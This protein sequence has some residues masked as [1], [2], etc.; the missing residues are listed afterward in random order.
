MNDPAGDRPAVVSRY[1]LR[2][3]PRVESLLGTDEGVYIVALDAFFE[4]LAADYEPETANGDT[5]F[6]SRLSLI[7]SRVRPIVAAGN[8][9]KL[10]RALSAIRHSRHLSNKVRHEFRVYA[11]EDAVAATQRFLAF[12]EVV[13]VAHPVL[14]RLREEIDRHWMQKKS[15]A[16]YHRELREQRL[17]LNRFRKEA[18]ELAEQVRHLQALEEDLEAVRTEAKQY[19]LELE[20]TRAASEKRDVRLDD[21]RRRLNEARLREEELIRRQHDLAAAREYI[22][23]ISRF[24]AYTRS[25]ADYERSVMLL[26]DE[27]HATVEAI[28]D[29][30]D[31]AIKGPAGTG[32]TL[33]LMHAVHQEMRERAEELP[34]GEVEEVAVFTFNKS[35]TRF[36][37]YL[38]RIIG[39][40]MP[41]AVIRHVDAFYQDQIVLQNLRISYE[42]Q[43]LKEVFGQQAVPFLTPE[44]F[45]R[46]VEEF[47][48]GNDLERE[49]YL[50]QTT[51]RP[52]RGQA[53]TRT[54]R[55]EVWRG[56]RRVIEEMVRRGEVSR[57]YAVCLITQRLRDDPDYRKSLLVRRVFLDE[58]Q[59]LSAAEI[60]LFKVIS[61]KGIVLAGD[62]QQMIYR[63]GSSYLRAGVDIRGRTR[64][65]RTNYRNTR[66]ICA[67]A[68]AYRS[69]RG[70]AHVEAHDE[71]HDEA[72]AHD[73]D[74]AQPRARLQDSAF[75]VGPGPE[76][77]RCGS[78]EEMHR[79]L[80]ERI[81]FFLE[82]LGYEAENLAVLA[83]RS[84]ILTEVARML[85]KEEIG[86]VDVRT[87]EFDFETSPGIRLSTL[88]SAKGLEFPVVF[89]VLPRLR[90]NRDIDPLE[91]IAQSRNLVHVSLTRAMDN[92]QVFTL[93]QPKEEALKD[94]ASAFERAQA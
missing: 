17:S 5:N 88:H 79:I 27:Q 33:V 1:S 14:Q 54:Q 22:D 63:M 52:G 45:H 11:L 62:E 50:E 15:P 89:L 87:D 44:E 53:L 91:A 57:Q 21:L 24:T 83:S 68:E 7:E 31:F 8:H 56:S 82:T 75:R 43:Y 72:R 41:D 59:D 71:A 84:A 76:H 51:R 38:A 36:N 9:R 47:I 70:E 64:I 90:V 85:E 80:A 35:L 74:Q 25:R 37:R 73:G 93:R 92:L 29:S 26:S 10:E 20:K 18:T 66:E 69:I 30:A 67:L 16:E 77:F 58:T 23:Y 60:A 13:A 42:E 78:E 39:S 34:F 86:T 19:R 12:F 6:P 49:E 4:G 40:D 65:L 55:E 32:K 2:N 46:E 81:H 3:L 61:R 94:L 48:F 28:R